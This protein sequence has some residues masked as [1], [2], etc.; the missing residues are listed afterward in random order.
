MARSRDS[1]TGA[2]PHPPT[3]SATWRRLV[4][5]VRRPASDTSAQPTMMKRSLTDGCNSTAMLG[6]R[7]TPIP[8]A[9]RRAQAHNNA[10]ARA[11]LDGLAAATALRAN[12]PAASGMARGR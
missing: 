4:R 10:L 5:N 9:P 2:G 7:P 1:A 12:T 11:A 3:R 8:K 6:S